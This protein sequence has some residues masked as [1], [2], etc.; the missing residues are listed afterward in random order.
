METVTGHES[1][2]ETTFDEAYVYIGGTW[3][4]LEFGDTDD[5]V[6]GGLVIYAPSVGI[7]QVDGDYGSFSRLSLDDYYP[8]Y[9]D[10]GTS[11]KINYYTPR[12]AG[13]QAGI[14]Y[15]PH[16]SDNGQ[17]VVAFRTRKDSQP[18]PPPLS[19]LAEPVFGK[20]HSP[21]RHPVVISRPQD[22][23]P[24]VGSRSGAGPQ[25]G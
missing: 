18:H 12:I 15:S 7:G 4:R 6:A 17:S 19:L 10:I 11:T 3:G 9:P 20:R 1:S 24:R 25:S 23:D 22:R 8:F 21:N 5:V 14:S 2:S 13:F 16:L